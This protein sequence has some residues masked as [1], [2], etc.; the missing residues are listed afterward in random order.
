MNAAM[1][2]GTYVLGLAAVFGGTV[3]VG[4][5]LGDP[6]GSPADTAARQSGDG[7]TSPTPTAIAETQEV[8]GGLQ[9]SQDGYTL[10]PR[11]TTLSPGKR[12]D[13][14]FTVAGPDG[15]PVT[16][17]TPLHGKKLH[18]IVVRRDMTGFQHLHPVEAGGGVW[19]V[20]LTLPAAGAYRVFTDVR[21]AGEPEQLTLGMDL[22]APGD[23]QPEA[24]PAAERSARVDDDYTVTVAG[25]LVP[26][27]TGKLTLSVREDGRPVTDLQPYLE[28]YGHLVVLRAGDLAYL[29]VHP[30]GAPG[31][32]TT[33][34][35]PDITFSAAVPSAGA[36]RLYLDFQHEETVR[37][38]EFTMTA[39]GPAEVAPAPAEPAEPSGHDESH[40]H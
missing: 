14:R 20:P 8:P 29:H 4:N 25:T 15:R 3:G 13:F 18:F 33:D 30:E 1:K 19:S 37:T 39:G 38:A 23:Y 36:Y 10:V 24:L 26:G 32:G 5:I 11:T 6:T 31:D 35:G 22:A 28:A 27:K 17:Y 9:I 7:G 16:R 34:P 12:T 2:L 40:G 21:P